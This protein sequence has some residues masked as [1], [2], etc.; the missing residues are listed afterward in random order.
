[1]ILE[2][3]SL[4][5]CDSVD[6]LSGRIVRLLVSYL[7]RGSIFG[8]IWSVVRWFW[9]CGRGLLCVT[10]Y[11]WY[12][13]YKAKTENRY[14][15]VIRCKQLERRI[16][17][18]LTNQSRIVL[19]LSIDNL[20]QEDVLNNLS[21]ISFFRHTLVTFHRVHCMSA[22]KYLDLYYLYGVWYYCRLGFC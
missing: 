20:L 9:R 15:N 1:M 18:Q 11:I 3:G 4:W 12:S 7:A 13:K 19:V 22:S 14:Y 5:S 10:K 6:S 2:V 16:T 8:M 21:S 17:V